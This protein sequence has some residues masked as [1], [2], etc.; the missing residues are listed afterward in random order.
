MTETRE[1]VSH[2]NVGEIE[3]IDYIADKLGP[4]AFRAYVL[5][6]IIKYASR[7]QHKGQFDADIEKIRNY[8]VILQEHEAKLVEAVPVPVHF[9]DAAD[10]PVGVKFRAV[11]DGGVWMRRPDGF[12]QYF[13]AGGAAGS[14]KWRAERINRY[15]PFEVVV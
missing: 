2:Y 4:D 9:D 14:G 12:F 5:G 10:A 3:T 1:H 15:A 11:K 8:A 13:Y 7:A 6:N